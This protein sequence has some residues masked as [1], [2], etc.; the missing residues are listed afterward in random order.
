MAVIIFLVGSTFDVSVML[1]LAPKPYKK[2]G[3]LEHTAHAC[4]VSPLQLFMYGLCSIL[5]ELCSK[6]Y[7]YK[8]GPPAHPE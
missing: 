3:T 2:R 8:F 4:A 7:D 1:A 5:L 6:I